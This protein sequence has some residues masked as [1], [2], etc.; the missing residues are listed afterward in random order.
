MKVFA[1]FLLLLRFSYGIKVFCGFN[2]TELRLDIGQNS[3]VELGCANPPLRKDKGGDPGLFDESQTMDDDEIIVI[4]LSLH[5]QNVDAGNH[6]DLCNDIDKNS[7]R[8]TG[9]VEDLEEEEIDMTK[10]DN[11]S[12]THNNE[13]MVVT[14]GKYG[15][16]CIKLM[17]SK[18][19]E[20][21]YSRASDSDSIVEVNLVSEATL[22]S[23]KP[24]DEVIHG[25]TMLSIILT[26]VALTCGNFLLGTGMD[27]ENIIVGFRSTFYKIF[28]RKPTASLKTNQKPK[29]LCTFSA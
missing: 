28:V 17:A 20:D 3:S 21:S 16:S 12:N 14:S 4:V 9:D 5:Q 23:K 6:F 2:Q 7:S 1:I 18:Y 26:Y 8:C 19:H 11:W 22:Y 10:Y 24:K 29:P 25:L 13:T 27:L 15:I